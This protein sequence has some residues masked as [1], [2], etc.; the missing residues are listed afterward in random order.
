MRKLEN[1]IRWAFF[2]LAIVMAIVAVL[3]KLANILG[4]TLWRQL[5]EQARL[6][7]ITAVAL[8]FSIALTLHEIVRALGSKESGSPK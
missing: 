3:Q 4:Y 7:E 8:L 5:P 6:V 2:Y 1:T